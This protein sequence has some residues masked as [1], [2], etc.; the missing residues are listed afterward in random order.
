M[1]AVSPYS[2]SLSRSMEIITYLNTNTTFRTILQ[3][4]VQGVHWDT[5]PKDPE[6]IRALSD[7]YRMNI[8]DTGNI[9]MTYPDYG[10]PMSY[11]DGAKQQNLDSAVNPYLC[12]EYVT[13]A[14][15]AKYEE[16]ASLSARTKAAIDAITFD[17]LTKDLGELRRQ[18]V[19]NSLI[20][21]MLNEKDAEMEDSLAALY[22][23][24]VKSK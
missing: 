23:V 20:N 1:F 21:D 24:Y 18:L 19:F 9:F 17:S 3:Y 10:L 5:D 16:L 4:G 12:F 6:V 13:D 7:D 11:W 15:R 8:V 22:A 2:K 14:N